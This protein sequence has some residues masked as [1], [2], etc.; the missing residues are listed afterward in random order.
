MDNTVSVQIARKLQRLI[1]ILAAPVAAQ[2]IHAVEMQDI[3]RDLNF[4][5]LSDE[6][7]EQHVGPNRYD[8]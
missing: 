1:D 3:R 8:A 7:I 2:K 4:S 5:G 6:Q